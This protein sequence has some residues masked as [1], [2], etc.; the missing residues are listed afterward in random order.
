[1]I[2]SFHSL[3]K[4]LF[5]LLLLLL[6]FIIYSRYNLH[7]DI[8]FSK[9]LIGLTFPKNVLRYKMYIFAFLLMVCVRCCT[10]MIASLQANLNN[11]SI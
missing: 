6:L 2:N 1:M 3:G 8:V 5:L 7:I 10:L 11:S 4:Y 9:N